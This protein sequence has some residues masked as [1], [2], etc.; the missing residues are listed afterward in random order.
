M[1][2]RGSIMHPDWS[3]WII[4]LDHQCRVYSLLINAYQKIGTL[5]PHHQSSWQ[6]LDIAQD[7]HALLFHAK[8]QPIPLSK[9]IPRASFIRVSSSLNEMPDR[10]NC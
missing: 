2:A 7:V 10:L 4:P 5:V 9:A 8:M 3:L 6:D 1:I